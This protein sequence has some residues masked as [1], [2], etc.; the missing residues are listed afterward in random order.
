MGTATIYQPT[1]PLGIVGK[2]PSTRYQGSKA[3][4]ANWIWE[5]VSD[6]D[7]L[8]CLDAFGGTGAI[9]YRLK[10]EGKQVTY[11]DYLRFN[12]HIGLALIENSHTQL[13][14]EEV[15]WILQR[16]QGIAYHWQLDQ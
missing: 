7:F 8:T 11:N 9:G 13:N 16:H 4:L 5:Q 15:E 3:K 14:P 12:Y 10:Q 1:L 2:F 6:F